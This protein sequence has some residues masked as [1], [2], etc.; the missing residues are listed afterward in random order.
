MDHEIDGRMLEM[1]GQAA[2]RWRERQAVRESRTEALNNGNP[3][4]ADSA[5]RVAKRMN[6]LVKSMRNS[7]SADDPFARPVA[8]GIIN[9]TTAFSASELERA[10]VPV[11]AQLEAVLGESRDFLS[12]DFLE[13]GASAARSVGRVLIRTGGGYAALGTGFLVGPGLMITN[14]HV[15]PD[16]KTARRCVLQMNHVLRLNGPAPASHSFDLDPTDIFLA[17]K[18]HDYALVR[19]ATQSREGVPLD[20]YGWL[21]LDGGQ[22]KILVSDLDQINIVQHPLGREKEVVLRNNRVLDLRTGS[23]ATDGMMGPFIHY[24]ADTEKG[25]SGSPVFNDSWEVI[26]LH[27]M[28]IPA[29]DAAGA[30]LDKDGGVWRDGGDPVER[31]QWVA[32][33][34]VRISALLASVAT[35]GDDVAMRQRVLA[36]LS[37]AA[38]E[39]VPLSARVMT[40]ERLD[41]S[42]QEASAVT[43]ALPRLATRTGTKRVTIP[44][45]VSISVEV[46]AG[47]A[48][49]GAAH[50]AASGSDA[51]LLEERLEPGDFAN[52]EGFDRQFLGVEIPLPVIKDIPRHGGLLAIPRPA[53][54]GDRHELRYH[55][56]SVLMSAGR[57]LAYVSACNLNFDAA[58]TCTRKEGRESWRTDP[59]I[60]TRDQLDDPY[61]AHEALDLGHLTRRDDTAW[62]TTKAGA[63]AANNDTFFYTNCAPQH[64]VFNRSGLSSGDHEHLWGDL[65]NH[66]SKQGEAQRLRLSVFNG[67]VFGERDNVLLDARTPD[68]FFKIVIW[69]DENADP[70]AI[71]F[72]LSQ[73]GLIDDL[74]KEG[75]D[76][77][78]FVIRQRRIAEIEGELDIS[79]GPVAGWDR[80]PAAAP[81]GARARG[82]AESLSDDV[83]LVTRLEDIRMV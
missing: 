53:R 7:A 29:T 65:E 10:P 56:Y 78:A 9:R 6:R 26:A 13:R 22:G 43:P 19:V 42:K 18:D 60:E 4:A 23:D 17:D 49:I 63:I 25:S 48:R 58:A 47:S 39:P 57:R 38:P 59:R 21:T 28:G 75:I 2:A 64:K 61:Y 83:I 34:G 41:K 51:T 73:A 55:H 31:L 1:A 30:Y 67:P 8:R 37:S 24:E 77:G 72:T 71:G 12:S 33:E 27:H 54:D 5:E 40:A 66:I 35:A 16:D 20:E 62:G 11:A 36:A 82:A 45:Q 79:F 52:R 15:L 81:K 3:L 46:D 76:P 80:F 70:A 69:R 68:A 74:Q 44:L 32:N 50:L 14:H